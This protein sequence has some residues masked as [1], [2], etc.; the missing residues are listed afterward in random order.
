MLI[1]MP[2]PAPTRHPTPVLAVLVMAG[3]TF[4]LSQ[5]LV[6]PALPALARDLDASTASASWV[7]TGFLL[8]ASVAT[9]IVGKLGDLYGKGRVLTVVMLVFA[10][11]SVTCALAP[12]IGVVIAGRVIQG[13]AGGVFPLAFGIIRDTFPRDRVAAGIGLLSASFGVGGGIGLPLAG[14]VVDNFDSR[15]CSGSA[16][17]RCRSPP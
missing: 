8:S 2:Q 7:L 6:V 1:T 4:A 5:T 15:G 17:S 14:V 9:P 12:T 13:V 10:A 16:C 3:I 11:G